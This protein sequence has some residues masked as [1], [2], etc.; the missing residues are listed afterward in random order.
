MATL[1]TSALL[2]RNRV[3]IKSVNFVVVTRVMIV[4]CSL[5]RTFRTTPT[6]WHPQQVYVKTNERTTEGAIALRAV[7]TVFVK[8]FIPALMKAVE[9]TVTGFGA[10]RETATT[11]AHLRTAS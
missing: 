6:L 2:D 3:V 8:L 5:L 7:I 11:L 10:T 9:P 1:L 4:G